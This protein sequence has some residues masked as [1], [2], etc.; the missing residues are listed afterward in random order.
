MIYP[1]QDRRGGSIEAHRINSHAHKLIPKENLET[2]VNLKVLF[3][4]CGSK[5]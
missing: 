1:F 2:Q 5:P 4:N 3:L